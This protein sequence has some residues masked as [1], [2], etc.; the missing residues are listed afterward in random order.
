MLGQEQELSDLEKEL[1]IETVDSNRLKLIEKIAVSYRNTNTEKHLEYIEN[2]LAL[3]NKLKN[4]R[5]EGVFVREK[6][7][8]YKK[9]DQLDSS[10][11]FYEKSQQLFLA[12]P[13]TTLFYDTESSIGNV[14][15]AQGK[16]DEATHYFI[17]AIKYFEKQNT[18]ASIKKSLIIKFN[19][20]GMHATQHEYQ[21]SVKEFK[22]ILYNV[23]T[24]SIPPLKRACYVNISGIYSE[25]KEIDSALVYAKKASVVP[26]G[27]RSMANLSVNLGSI[28]EKKKLYNKALESFQEALNL[29][30]DLGDASGIIKS[31]NNIGNIYTFLGNYN[32]AEEHLLK[33]EKNLENTEDSYSLEENY[34]MFI[35][36]YTQK[37]D[38]KKAFNYQQKSI[39]LKDSILS[40]EKQKVITEIETKY[41]VEKKELVA[42]NALKEKEIA[43][44]K[45][46]KEKSV[47]LSTIV[48][49]CLIL[50][51]LVLYFIYFR[52]KKKQQQ[53][54]YELNQAKKQIKLEQQS[55]ESELTALRS[56]M[57]PHFVFN[58]LN[59]I[60]EY[61]ITNNK[62][63]AGDY[64][65][66]FADLMRR[67]LKH[68]QSNFITL[69]EEIETLEMYLQLEKVR[70]EDTFNYEIKVDETIDI[71]ELTVPVMILQPF[72]ENAIKHGLLHKED[73]RKL[74]VEFF[75]ENKN[76][77]INVIDNG[78]GREK[79]AEINNTRSDKHK[80][81]ATSAIQKRIELLNQNNARKIAVKYFDI[82]EGT[83][84]EILINL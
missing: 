29:Y 47:L 28:Y 60:Q 26:A 22:E 46:E 19:L 77:K 20:A 18:S 34:N 65:G 54:K 24:D 15:K 73:N 70:F 83:K 23:K 82:D 58:A 36:L 61:I 14:K 64:L 63:S 11:F 1:Q 5:A 74:W 49:I 2:G 84:V 7:V 48:L 45:A 3:S 39:E 76:L 55:R 81:Y 67:Y 71:D 33:A 25:L 13:D 72:V 9:A 44:V 6:G 35:F 30:L 8:Y 4:K 43:G 27:K 79:S 75:V 17:S 31:N 21:K 69:D 57:N 38:Y 56:Q 40:V 66:L 50:I 37:G 78:I 12:I 62:D 10:L 80:S 52:T 42:S 68:S 59:S 51:V 16:F 41:E 53:I 32:L